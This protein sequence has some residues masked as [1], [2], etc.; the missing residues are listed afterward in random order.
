M[1]PTG[2]ETRVFQLVGVSTATQGGL[3]PA[4]IIPC[5]PHCGC[6]N[7]TPFSFSFEF[8]LFFPGNT[9]HLCVEYTQAGIVPWWF[10]QCAHTE[11]KDH[12]LPIPGWAP[13]FS[14]AGVSSC[15]GLL[16]SVPLSSGGF[17]SLTGVTWLG[18]ENVILSTWKLLSRRVHTNSKQVS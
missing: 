10:G 7:R 11:G 8:N 6:S 14:A 9:D 13:G 4:Q 3:L 12:A 18:P 15:V 16:G 1:V 17:F 2:K 5:L